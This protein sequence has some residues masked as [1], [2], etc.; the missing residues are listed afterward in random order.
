MAIYQGFRTWRARPDDPLLSAMPLVT[1]VGGLILAPIALTSEVNGDF[2]VT[3]LFWW[4]AGFS[5]TARGR[6]IDA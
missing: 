1:F 4:A 2:S 3:F 5:L 6:Q